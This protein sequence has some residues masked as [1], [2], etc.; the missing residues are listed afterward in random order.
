MS[1]FCGWYSPLPAAPELDR[2]AQPLRRHRA[3]PLRSARCPAGAVALAAQPVAGRLFRDDGLLIAMWGGCAA[4][5][6]RLWRS[7][8]A[9]G[10]SQL[11]GSFAFALIDEYRNEAI[12][13]VDR[14]A[15]RPLYYQ[16]SGATLLFATCADSLAALAPAASALDPQALY[17]YLYFQYVPPGSSAVRGQHRLGPGETLHFHD[18][19]AVRRRASSAPL[20]VTQANRMAARAGIGGL[21]DALPRMAAA[22]DQPFGK[23]AL[24]VAHALAAQ[25]AARGQGCLAFEAVLDV[26]RHEAERRRRR[27]ARM[28]S[29]VRQ[30]LVE[31]LLFRLLGGMHGAAIDGLRQ[32]VADS[33]ACL[34]SSMQGGALLAHHGAEQVLSRELMAACDPSRPL[35]RL[36]DAWWGAYGEPEENRLALLDME[37]EVAG[38]A[39][40]AA[41]AACELHGIELAVPALDGDHASVTLARPASPAPWFAADARLRELA[42]D[43]LLDLRRRQLVRADFIDMLLSSSLEAHA[44]MAWTLMMLEQW[45]ARRAQ[46]PRARQG[47]VHEQAA[48][49]P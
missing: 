16:V 24:A 23:P 9:A 30:L 48:C 25:A 36:R 6:A 40:P 11:G 34:P 45:L 28:P 37:Y 22:L 2:M 42:Y 32:R 15:S 10:C 19:R 41:L 8:G 13:G 39:L 4:T 3:L 14:L 18:G 12:L 26:A 1:G 35:A 43:S 46:A 38:G 33:V 29:A 5:L 17:E 21:A 27:Y 31:P 44:D 47:A 20:P 49:V 7:H